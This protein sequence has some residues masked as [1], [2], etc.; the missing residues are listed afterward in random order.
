MQI[1]L[2]SDTHGL[3]RPET[4]AALRGLPR[5]IHA[6]DIG[7]AEVL[8]T[9]RS[10]APV[11]AVRGN[12]DQGAWAS[13]LPQRLC[14]TLAGVRI[15]VLHELEDLDGDIDL[16][17][18]GVAVVIS[19][20]SHRPLIRRHAGVLYVNPGSAGP[21][22]FNLPVTLGYLELDNGGARARIERLL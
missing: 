4:L 22:R 16:A 10:L 11:D 3:V 21:R 14:L 18:Q 2:I 5:I 17:A 9:L 19:G 6:G 7:G 13:T 1:G 20:H 12:N 15:D 8:E